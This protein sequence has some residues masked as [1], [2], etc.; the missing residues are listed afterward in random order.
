ML[1]KNVCKFRGFVLDGYPK[2]HA[3]AEMLFFPKKEEEDGEEEAPK[4]EFDARICPEYFVLLDP[5]LEERRARAMAICQDQADGT[6]CN[7]G[8]FE[9]REQ[10]YDTENRNPEGLP[11]LSD[12]FADHDIEQLLVEGSHN[13]V[14]AVRLLIEAKGRA[15]N[16][17]AAERESAIAALKDLQDNVQWRAEAQQ[18]ARQERQDVEDKVLAQRHAEERQRIAQLQQA[19]KEH[20]DESSRPLKKYL[21]RNV[22]PI[23]TSG[24]LETCQVMPEDPVEYLAEYLFTHAH[25]IEVQELHA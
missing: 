12:F 7:A 4:A 21:E 11:S 13:V 22:V 24:L 23:L 19:E 5:P 17:M 14:E 15:W 9:R 25:D 6:H 10:R 2:S 20:L 16:Y 8:D 18:Q 3:G 1:Q